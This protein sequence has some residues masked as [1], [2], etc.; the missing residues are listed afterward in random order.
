MICSP[1]NAR[2]LGSCESTSAQKYIR[3]KTLD[4]FKICC[5][6]DPFNQNNE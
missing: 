2:I 4:P 1:S 3:L 5:Y 6:L